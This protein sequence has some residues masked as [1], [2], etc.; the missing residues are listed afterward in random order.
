MKTRNDANNM[1]GQ[2][3]EGSPWNHSQWFCRRFVLDEAASEIN[4]K[5]ECGKTPEQP[6]Q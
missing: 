2:N 4:L 1:E 3:E 6:F 5:S